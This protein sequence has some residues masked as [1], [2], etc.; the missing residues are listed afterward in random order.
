MVEKNADEQGFIR[1]VEQSQVE[2]DG[3]AIIGRC[4]ARAQRELQGR[5]SRAAGVLQGSDR[6]RQRLLRGL[7]AL[8]C[9]L[10]AVCGGEVKEVSTHPRVVQQRAHDHAPVE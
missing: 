6:T 1:G 3:G 8:V 10:D 9:V 7:A 2:A 5:A 4:M